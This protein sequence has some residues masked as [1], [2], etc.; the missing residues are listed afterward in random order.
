[1]MDDVTDTSHIP[2]K[3][4][5]PLTDDQKKEYGTII[6]TDLN[7]IAQQFNYTYTS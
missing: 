6:V 4:K 2:S 5:K 7:K 3:P 1:M